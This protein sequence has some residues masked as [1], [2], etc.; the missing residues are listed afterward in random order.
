[1]VFVFG[2]CGFARFDYNV[3]HL[4][5]CIYI[6]IYIY[7]QDGTSNRSVVDNI[8]S[9]GDGALMGEVSS[10]RLHVRVYY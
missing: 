7:N 10:M 4:F 5:P 6:Y 1:M 8:V 3:V 9:D 2:W